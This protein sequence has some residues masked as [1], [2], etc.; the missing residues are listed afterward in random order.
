[1][2]R[3]TSGTLLAAGPTRWL[4]LECDESYRCD[5]MVIDRGHRRPAD[6][7]HPARC[8][9]A[10]LRRHLPRRPDGGV[11]ATQRAGRQQRAPARPGHRRRSGST[12]VTTSSDQTLGGRTLVWSPD[13]RWLFV[14]DGAGRV[15]ALSRAGHEVRAR[16]PVGPIDQIALRT[17]AR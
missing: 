5:S 8:V 11:A 15:L 3:I 9:R 12:G 1:M 6:P 13:S 16:R 10:E 7:A 14:T 2:H 17:T 4:T